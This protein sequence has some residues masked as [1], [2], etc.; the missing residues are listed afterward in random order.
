[1]P[2]FGSIKRKELIHYLRVLGFEGPYSGRKHQ[3]MIKDEIILRLPN[4][5]KND[6]G[7][8]LLSRILKQA[9]IDKKTW[10]EL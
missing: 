2:H 10:E 3:F 8:E 1:M 7:K 4:P 9:K 6:I 5:H